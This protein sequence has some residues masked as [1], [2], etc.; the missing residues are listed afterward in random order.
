M[1]L[2]A[3]RGIGSVV[4]SGLLVTMVAICSPASATDAGS[5]QVAANSQDAAAQPSPKLQ[6]VIVT[7]EKRVERLQDV[8]VPVTAISAEALTQ[9]NTTRLEDY[10]TSIP[11]LS[12]FQ[13]GAA[14]DEQTIS[15][16]GINA[17]DATNPTVGITVDDVPYGAS[18][19]ILGNILPDFDPSDL[20]RVEVLRGPQG[21]L[22]GASSMGGLIRYVTVEPAF[23]KVSGNIQAGV[24]SVQNGAEL[25]EYARGAVNVPL[26]DT[27]A[28][29]ATGFVR[30]DPGYIDN[31]NTHLD[32]ANQIHADGG[33]I[34]GLWRPSDAVSV[35]VAALYQETKGGT[36]EVGIGPG[37]GDLQQF[38]IPGTGTFDKKIEAYSALVTAKF[39]RVDLTSVT[40]YNVN[41]WTN[42]LDFSYVLGGVATAIGGPQLCP[43]GCGAPLVSTG[44]S[45]KLTQE[46]RMTMALGER[47]DW[48]LGVFYTHEND[49]EIQTLPIQDLGSGGAIVGNMGTLSQPY[50]DTEYAAFTDVTFH[51]TDRFSM[52]LGGR[53][54]HIKQVFPTVSEV[55]PLFG[56]TS[57]LPEE[58]NTGSKFTYLVTPQYRLSSDFMIYAR[59]ASGYRLGGSNNFNPDPA[60]QREFIPDT[61]KNYEVGAKGDFLDHRL[62]FD[63]SVYYIDWQDIQLT[64]Y[65]PANH[66]G[67]GANGGGAKSEGVELSVDVIPLTGLRI[68]G[69][70]TYDNAVLTQNIPA[71]ALV[72]G[73]PGDR[74]EYVP[75]FSGNLRVDQDFALSGSIT[76]FAGAAAS[77]VGD[78]LAGFNTPGV[79]RD[80]YGSYTRVDLHAGTRI[81]SWTTTIYVNNLTNVRGEVGGGPSTAGLAGTLNGTHVPAFYYIQPRTVG[82]SVQKVF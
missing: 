64:L 78:R 48:L 63:A 74:I 65:D 40:G 26:S 6:E 45:E 71:A 62:S 20:A 33:R 76:G 16:R 12:F 36:D 61:T 59:A 56:G 72:Y 79:P 58:D 42:A 29:R 9:S 49:P 14:G 43:V 41:K 38:F 35:K 7:A 1:R 81:D 3:V 53:E 4:H 69:W 37:V 75:R 25:G 2:K 60:V 55:G 39:G 82:F 27:F 51:F 50:N 5:S 30:Q 18:I 46:I 17:G 80:S 21:T 57:Y 44:K 10:Y 34:A 31:P 73:A 8:P 54:S 22:Y 11:G 77:Y 47:V 67:Y 52:Q 19:K 70:V 32:G 28:V 24:S 23:D 68:G 13:T 66:L 15:I